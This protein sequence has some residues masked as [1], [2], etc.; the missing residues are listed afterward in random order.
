MT[1]LFVV[2]AVVPIVR[3]VSAA[4]FG[5]KMIGV[6]AGANAVGI[7][8]YLVGKRRGAPAAAA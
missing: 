7:G 3:V 8:L 4:A 6:V 1:L 5:L 2:F